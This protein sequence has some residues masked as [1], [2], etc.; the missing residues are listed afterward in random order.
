M[1]CS[2]CSDPRVL[3]AI[4]AWLP[5][6]KSGAINISVVQARDWLAEQYGWNS[7]A[8]VLRRCLKDHHGYSVR[9]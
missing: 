4:K 6:W 1:K 9:A 3:A 2:A 8:S 5:L 7:V